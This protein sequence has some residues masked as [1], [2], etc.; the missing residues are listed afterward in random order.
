MRRSRE[1]IG[2][3]WNGVPVCLTLSAATPAARR[4]SWK[5]A[6]RWFLQ[7]KEIFSWS[8]E[9][10]CRIS[11]ASSSRAR[12]NSPPRSSSR[13][14]SGPDK[15]TKISGFS[16]ALRRR[17][18]NDPIFEAK[19]AVGD[20]RGQEFVDSVCGRNFVHNSALGF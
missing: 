19:P 8:A 12:S 20:H 11:S 3:K 13:L 9:G 10:K 1:D 4:N 18:D 14:E 6:D 15:S 2:A 16:I 5:R 7:S 17:V